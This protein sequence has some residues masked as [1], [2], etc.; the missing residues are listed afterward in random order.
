MIEIDILSLIDRLEE[1]L[2]AGRHSPFTNRVAID[3]RAV[4]NLIDQ[5]RIAIPQE[6]K[7]AREMQL[8]R[9]QYIAQAHEEAR[10]IIA[11]ARQD[12]ARMLD[13]H[14]LRQ[15]A[16]ARSE[17]IIQAAEDDALRIRTGSDAYAETKLRELG[18]QIG[19]LQRVIQNGLAF[20]DE[21]RGQATGSAAGEKPA[22]Q[23]ASPEEGDKARPSR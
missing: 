13:E 19:E 21:Q 14:A 18:H 20:L 23:E 16:Q 8:E 15:E 17:A 6:I 10:R 3:E 2:E 22:P 9:D 11:Q 12:A 4:Y 7:Q 1:L 5:M